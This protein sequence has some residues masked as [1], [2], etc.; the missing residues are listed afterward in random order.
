MCY[1]MYS[2][3][4]FRL[5]FD[6]VEMDCFI[7]LMLQLRSSDPE[8]TLAL[9]VT[10]YRNLL[11][12][13]FLIRCCARCAYSCYCCCCCWCCLLVAVFVLFSFFPCIFSFSRRPPGL[14][15]PE[16]LYIANNFEK[17]KVG[18]FRAPRTII[19]ISLASTILCSG[20]HRN[21]KRARQCCK[22][23]KTCFFFS[24]S[25]FLFLDSTL[26][27]IGVPLFFASLIQHVH[28]IFGYAVFFS[29]LDFRL[30]AYSSSISLIDALFGC[31]T[32]FYN[33]QPL[34]VFLPKTKNPK[35]EK[36]QQSCK[37]Q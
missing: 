36:N 7:L 24:L 6:A 29:L 21:A 16:T 17:G 1:V 5:L 19:K 30:F 33:R 23:D 3:V 31:K 37:R 8:P 15:K 10:R 11:L 20:V 18:H 12:P 13:I 32:I 14:S 4:C 22:T 25:L 27:V 2:V 28:K 26:L 34:L 35:K 9:A